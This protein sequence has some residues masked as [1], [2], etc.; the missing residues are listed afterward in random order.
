[1]LKI[2]Q[3]WAQLLALCSNINLDWP[4]AVYGWL[5]FCE[6]ATSAVGSWVTLDCLLYDRDGLRTA[7]QRSIITVLTP[8]IF[9]AILTIMWLLRAAWLVM[10]RK[11]LDSRTLWG[12]LGK[13]LIITMLATIFTLY[14]KASKP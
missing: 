12:Y 10:V 6:A 1:M 7:S 4:S 14:P 3:T 8:A 11:K 9:F 2:F 5:A 13:R